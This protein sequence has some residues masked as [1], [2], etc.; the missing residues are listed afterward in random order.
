MNKMEEMDLSAQKLEGGVSSFNNG[1]LS[2][3]YLETGKKDGPAIVFIHSLIAS[4]RQYY[5]NID[6][7]TD[8]YR[9]VCMSLRGHGKSDPPSPESYEGYSMEKF[10][11]DVISLCDHLGIDSFHYV[12]N[13]M[14]GLI[15]Y[16]LLKSHPQRLN[17][18]TTFGS[19]PKFSFPSIL[20]AG[21]SRLLLAIAGIA[22]VS[23]FSRMMANSACYS[24]HGRQFLINRLVSDVNWGVSK[25]AM[26]NLARTDYLDVLK[27]SKKPFLI[28]R[29]SNDFGFNTML[30]SGIKAAENNPAG[31]VKDLERAGH[32]AN[33][34]RPNRISEIILDFLPDG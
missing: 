22:G 21:Y 19:P 9:V 6:H 14:G 25:Y 32:I 24:D 10:A 12:G 33:L 5:P 13:S 20:A 8:K 1:E 23:R 2:L 26:V 28:I 18:L 4:L 31:L 15:G 11:G 3:E 7:F 17:S 34:D 16:Q 29:A 27:D 30:K